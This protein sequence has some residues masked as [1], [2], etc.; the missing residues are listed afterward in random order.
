MAAN[1][2][3][4]NDHTNEFKQTLTRLTLRNDAMFFIAMLYSLKH[5]CLDPFIAGG[6]QQIAATDGVHIFYDRELFSKDSLE[7]RQY[8]LVHEIL[9]VV[10]Y[11]PLRR[12]IRD[13]Q[14]WN[15]AADYVVNGMIHDSGAFK[16]PATDIQPNAKF[17][18]LSTE[19]VYDLLIKDAQ[20]A[21]SGGKQSGK[22]EFG[23]WVRGPAQPGSSPGSGTQLD[24]HGPSDVQDYNPDANGGTPA[25]Q[26][27]REIGINTEK[28]LQAAKAAGQGSALM[29]EFL[30][31][32]QV[33]REP[34]YAHLRRYMN[35]LHER[36]YNWSRINARRAVLH[37][38]VS[39]DMKSECMGDVVES[40][41][42]SGSLTDPQLA[43]ISAHTKDIM[44]ECRPK[45]LIIIRHTD[46]VTDVEIFEG[47]EYEGYKLERKSTGGTDFR[48][49]FELIESDF[50]EAQ[51]VLMFTDMYGPFPEGCSKD[52]LWI[53]STTEEHVKTPFGERIQADFND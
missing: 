21:L 13:P 45:R 48:P 4:S 26:V 49:V 14:I 34:W 39:P 35:V 30:K 38:I 7:D 19:Q 51:V 46:R 23:N 40:I 9:H 8:T 1:P 16:I 37:N 11:H 27:E 12:G 10:Y 52:T 24:G 47:P 44:K 32:A 28:A 17:K 15:I 3:V 25:S 31:E 53:T 33:A 41:D 6:K 22:G 2:K 43:A 50:P 18:G 20:Q 36:T 29:K 5:V 42:E